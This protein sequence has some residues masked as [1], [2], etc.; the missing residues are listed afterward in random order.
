MFRFFLAS[1]I[2]LFLFCS[3]PSEKNSGNFEKDNTVNSYETTYDPALLKEFDANTPTEY[4]I[5]PGDKIEILS[6]VLDK[7]AKEHTVSPDGKITVY[8]GKEIVVSGLTRLEAEKMVDFTLSRLFKN[9]SFG[10]RILS[11]ENNKV[12]V[13]GNVLHPG[14]LKVDGK[15]TLLEILTRAGLPVATKEKTPSRRCSILRS[16]DKILWVDTVELLQKGNLSLNFNL[17]NGDT[18]YFPD[19]DEAYVYL[20][21]EIEQPGAYAINTGL[22][23]LKA[24]SYAGGITE[25]GISSEIQLIREAK[26]GGETVTIDL[27]KFTS[28]ANYSQNYKLKPNDIIYIPRKGVAKVNYYLRMINPFAQLFIVGNIVKTSTSSNSGSSSGTSVK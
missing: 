13:L 22:S 21:G 9:A 26:N 11:H 10:L 2:F 5:G 12:F 27:N 7:I 4:K 19:Q 20:M 1:L 28:D 23:V 6:P 14:V 3:S 25:N 17:R 18:V 8:P 16:Q 15:I 24:I